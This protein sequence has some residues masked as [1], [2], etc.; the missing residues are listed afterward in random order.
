MSN[1][2][3]WVIDC[4][5]NYEIFEKEITPLSIDIF[6]MRA[7]FKSVWVRKLIGKLGVPYN[8]RLRVRGSPH[9]HDYDAGLSLTAAES[10]AFRIH[11]D[12]LCLARRIASLI[13]LFSS[14][15][16]RA[17]IKIPRNLAFGTFGLPIFGFINNFAYDENN[18]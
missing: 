3:F 9:P 8:R 15:E 4:I 5:F 14:G 12:L 2:D 16:T 13:V 18:C 7:I 11:S 6:K 17:C 1:S 10:N